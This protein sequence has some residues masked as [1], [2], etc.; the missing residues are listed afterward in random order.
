MVRVTNHP[1]KGPRFSP[2]CV[3]LS[4]SPSL[5]KAPNPLA[6]CSLASLSSYIKSTWVN[7]KCKCFGRKSCCC[8][9]PPVRW[10]VFLS[11][12]V[13]APTS[14]AAS[15]SRPVGRPDSQLGEHQGRQRAE[16]T[17]PF[18]LTSEERGLA[19]CHCASFFVGF[20]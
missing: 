3:T 10:L 12:C 1:L 14:G 11:V 8:P 5:S 4:L 19:A 9:L 15:F 13:P 7:M 20:T 16:Q 18:L 6:D 17:H 2:H